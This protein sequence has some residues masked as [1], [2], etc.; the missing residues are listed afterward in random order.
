MNVKLP[1]VCSSN[2]HQQSNFRLLSIF[3][4]TVSCSFFCALR[5]STQCIFVNLC[6]STLCLQCSF[7]CFGMEVKQYACYFSTK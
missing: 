3:F 1:S 7:L 5:V 6:V 4:C 2:F